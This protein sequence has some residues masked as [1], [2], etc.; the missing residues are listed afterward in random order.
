MGGGGGAGAN[1]CNWVVLVI[2]Y[3]EQQLRILLAKLAPVGVEM[4]REGRR[5]GTSNCSEGLVRMHVQ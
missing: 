4:G 5:Q 1:G 2:Y 3:N